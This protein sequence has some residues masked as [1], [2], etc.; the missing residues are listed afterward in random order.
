MA[1]ATVADRPDDS[2]SPSTIDSLDLWVIRDTA[3]E[4][5][6]SGTI[7]VEHKRLFL[8]LYAAAVREITRRENPEADPGDLF[9]GAR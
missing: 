3:V 5:L 7:P 2:P 1:R 4:R 9:A 6:S 8:D